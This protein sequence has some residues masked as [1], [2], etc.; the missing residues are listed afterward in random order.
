MSPFF[1]FFAK[2][3]IL[4]GLITVT[5]LLLGFN[6]FR[7]L[8][9]D[10]CPDTDL[11]RLLFTATYPGAAPENVEPSV[12]NTIE[13]SLKLVMGIDRVISTS[14]E[15]VSWVDVFIDPDVKDMA[16]VKQ[17]VRDAVG[18]EGSPIFPLK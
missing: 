18:R 15:N 11:G 10:Q 16:K 3:H 4:A 12:T 7:T 14:T 1:T 5:I 2:R 8:R 9:R 17:N 13:D 6:S